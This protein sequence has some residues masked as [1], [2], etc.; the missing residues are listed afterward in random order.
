MSMSDCTLDVLL[1][2]LRDLDVLTILVRMIDQSE[3]YLRHLST[4]FMCK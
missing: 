2:H 1:N 3:P 4:M